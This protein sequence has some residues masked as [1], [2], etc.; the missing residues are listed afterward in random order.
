MPCPVTEVAKHTPR[1][2]PGAP[3]SEPAAGDLLLGGAEIGAAP[4]ITSG[5]ISAQLVCPTR[6]D[7]V[8]A[9]P[10]GSLRLP[11]LV[12]TASDEGCV[13]R[14]GQ[15]V[16]SW[17]STAAQGAGSFPLGEAHE[18][19]VCSR[20]QGAWSDFVQD[21]TSGISEGLR[22]LLS[23]DMENLTWSLATLALLPEG[24]LGTSASISGSPRTPRVSRSPSARITHG[25]RPRPPCPPLYRLTLPRD[26]ILL[27]VSCWKAPPLDSEGHFQRRS[28]TPA[29][30]NIL[31]RFFVFLLRFYVDLVR[32]GLGAEPGWARLQEWLCTPRVWVLWQVSQT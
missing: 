14:P 9:F 32:P 23:P 11:G 10:S 6:T 29:I 8:K 21:Q 20:P 15:A 2:D 12:D 5:Y 4:W 1:P 7:S 3:A 27:G 24:R 30:T 31:C 22:L 16:G 28:R 18:R 19:L 13:D 26:S 25:P 17:P